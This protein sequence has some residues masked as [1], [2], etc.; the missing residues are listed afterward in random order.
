M[1]GP[2]LNNPRALW[3]EIQR[4]RRAALPAEGF[5]RMLARGIGSPTLRPLLRRLASRHQPPGAARQTSE[6]A[7][8]TRLH[9]A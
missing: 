9:V 4:L 3:W 2:I 1:S 8:W 6:L 5:A 7:Y